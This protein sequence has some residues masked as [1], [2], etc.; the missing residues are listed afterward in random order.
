MGNSLVVQWFKLCTFS[1]GGMG[2]ILGPEN[3]IPHS[4][5]HGQKMQ[6]RKRKK[7]LKDK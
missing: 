7:F 1:E 5:R 2:S 3:K 6:E 4:A